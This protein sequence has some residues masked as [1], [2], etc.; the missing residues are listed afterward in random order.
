[1]C[2]HSSITKQNIKEE[3]YKNTAIFVQVYVGRS[4]TIWEDKRIAH[5]FDVEVSS[6]T[7]SLAT[8]TVVSHRAPQNKTQITP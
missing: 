3:P 5:P 7:Q 4:L 1:M 8:T 2:Y 6:C